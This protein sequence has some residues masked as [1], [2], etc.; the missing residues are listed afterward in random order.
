MEHCLLLQPGCCSCR[1]DSF[2]TEQGSQ[3]LVVSHKRKDEGHAD[4]DGTVSP[5][6]LLQ[7]LLCLFGHSYARPLSL[8]VTGLS[9]P[10]GI[11]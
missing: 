10:L 7:T 8:F 4:I 1:D 11:M 6:V 5:P 9:T 3:W 2:R